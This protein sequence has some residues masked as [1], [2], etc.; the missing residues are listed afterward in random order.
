MVS[1][2]LSLSLSLSP[3]LPL[4]PSLSPSLSLLVCVCVCVCACARARVIFASTMGTERP[5]VLFSE[6]GL[7]L[8]TSVVPRPLRNVAATHARENMFNSDGLNPP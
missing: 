3:S 4:S 1:L 2:S 5:W 8:L 7:L 6:P